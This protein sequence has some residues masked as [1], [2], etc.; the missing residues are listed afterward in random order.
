MLVSRTPARNVLA[1]ADVNLHA[2]VGQAAGSSLHYT[3][4]RGERRCRDV[5]PARQ[6][7]AEREGG[8]MGGARNRRAVDVR[9][10]S[11]E[12]SDAPAEPVRTLDHAPLD[13]PA[14]SRR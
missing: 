6:R 11:G 8:E 2:V 1:Y 7:G 3:R 4:D 13:A 10:A 14:P 9:R 12:H 5:V